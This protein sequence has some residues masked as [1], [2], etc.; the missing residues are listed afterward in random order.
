MALA[1]AAM[2]WSDIDTAIVTA[3]SKPLAGLAAEL[4]DGARIILLCADRTTPAAAAQLL[5]DRGFGRSSMTVLEH[6]G[7]AAERRSTLVASA[8]PARSTSP[9]STSSPSLSSPTGLAPAVAPR[10]PADDAYEHDGQ[11]TKR[12]VRAL[13]LAAL[14]PR[15]GE[16]LWDVGAGSG[17]IGIEWLRGVPRARAIGI[18]ADPVRAARARA[19]A[20]RLGVPALT[21]V[22]GRA[23]AALAGLPPP[24]AIFV[25]GGFSE[26]TM[27]DLCWQ[28]L[29]PGGRL[30]ANAVT[31]ETEAVLL[32]AYA[33]LGGSLTRIAIDRA[34]PVGR[35]TGWRPAMPVTQW[36]VTKPW[37]GGGGVTVYFIGAG[38]GDPDLI[39]V[40]GR[41]LIERC[42][43]CLYAGSLVP[44]ALV[45]AAPAGATVIDTASLDLDAIVGHLAAANA[46]GH[47]VARLHSGDPSIYS[48]IGEQIAALDQPRHRLGNRPRRARLRRRRGAARQ[49]TDGAGSGSDGHPHPHLDPLVGDAAGRGPRHAGAIAGDAGDPPVGKGAAT[50]RRRIVAVLRRRL[51]GDPGREG[52]LAGRADHRGDARDDRRRRSLPPVSCAPRSSSSAAASIARRHSAKPPLLGRPRPASEAGNVGWVER[53]LARSPPF[54]QC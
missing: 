36:A 14:G 45:E 9:T 6:L 49:G 19:N 3:C 10:R 33:R 53:L 7:G 12:E 8:F 35:L 29:K 34:D 15:P 50:H 31:L 41:R 42:P 37:T 40:K 23:P 11:I 4:F 54:A 48:A 38:P 39:T 44:R 24:D 26:P 47:D 27:L 46:A 18:E 1:R 28:R 25:G 5:V 32:A 2:G 22:E 52:E 30:V 20:E 13:T 21:I 43:V 16:L 17:S 51:S